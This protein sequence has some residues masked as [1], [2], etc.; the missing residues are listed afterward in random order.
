[1]IVLKKELVSG[2]F[3][4]T[5]RQTVRVLLGDRRLSLPWRSC[6]R[7]MSKWKVPFLQKLKKTLDFQMA[8]VRMWRG[9]AEYICNQS[10]VI[11]PFSSLP[12]SLPSPGGG[13]GVF[14]QFC[15]RK[16]LMIRRFA[17]LN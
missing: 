17:L 10:E 3:V 8:F 5:K 1:M 7:D 6:E 2:E 14:T 13:F 9:H 4:K 12:V 16:S 11:Y 15:W